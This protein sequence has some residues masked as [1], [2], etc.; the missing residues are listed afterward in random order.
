MSITNAHA[1]SSRSKSNMQPGYSNTAA[2]SK[3][4]IESVFSEDDYREDV[5]GYMTA[6]DVSS[7]AA[8]RNVLSC[9]EKPGVD[10]RLVGLH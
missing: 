10:S 2:V 7:I 5:L 1:E 9:A 8:K 3:R 6:M 4:A